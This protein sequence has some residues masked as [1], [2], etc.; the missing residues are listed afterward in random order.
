MRD[1]TD[2]SHWRRCRTQG[3]C[4]NNVL[5]GRVD[6]DARAR[7]PGQGLRD[8]RPRPLSRLQEIYSF[9]PNRPDSLPMSP[10][11]PPAP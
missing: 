5:A 7:A 8:A 9:E 11:V 1:R 4:P 6:G 3:R 2:L 10:L